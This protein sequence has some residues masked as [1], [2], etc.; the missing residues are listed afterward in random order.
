LADARRAAVAQAHAAPRW[1]A[2]ALP[3]TALAAALALWLGTGTAP[4]PLPPPSPAADVTDYAK[5][6]VVATEDDAGTLDE[7]LEFYAWLDAQAQGG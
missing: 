2:F 3:A 1:R 5:G 6:L 7:D 4:P